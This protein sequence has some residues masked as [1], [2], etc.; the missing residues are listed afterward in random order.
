MMTTFQA[1]STLSAYHVHVDYHQP[2]L[3]DPHRCIF[4][5]S[6]GRQA[7]ES[8]IVERFVM[9][10]RRRGSWKGHVVLLTDAPLDRYS[11]LEERD[12]HFIVMHPRAEHFNW[13]TK[14]DMP[15]KR[16]KTYVLDYV[17]S[18][19]R[20]DSVQL[21]YYLDVDIIIGNSLPTF[22]DEIEGEYNVSSLP[23]GQETAPEMTKHKESRIYFFK[24]NFAKTPVQGGQ[25]ILE[26]D[27]SRNCLLL[28]RKLMDTRTN[29]TKDQPFLKSMLAKNSSNTR[30]CQMTI[31]EQEPHL[32]F[33]SAE[34]VKAMNKQWQ[35]QK[36]YPT[37][38][39]IKNTGKVREIPED[40]ETQYISDVLHLR[41]WDANANV[42]T[43]MH[44]DPDEPPWSP[45]HVQ[46]SWTPT[47]DTS[48]I[49]QVEF[50]R[51]TET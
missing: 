41:W 37:L 32:H 23:K 46:S 4:L 13:A 39:H 15:Y 10:T 9:S 43:K 12:D 1:S 8:K 38:L 2:I 6:M 20:L 36:Y 29:E 34:S 14:K 7:A 30:H 47:Y 25:I 18:D 33:P 5:I 28:W 24:G 31:M 48:N 44:F 16:F 49:S 45:N 19:P 27:S 22:F 42:G 50:M 17:D 11:A 3:P 35:S 26:R 21:V 40:A 51:L